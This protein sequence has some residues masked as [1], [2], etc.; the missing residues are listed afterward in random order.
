VIKVN[1]NQLQGKIL[2]FEEF[3]RYTLEDI[4]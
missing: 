4:P 3:R 1:E 2:G